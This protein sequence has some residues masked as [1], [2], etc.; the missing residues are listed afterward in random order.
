MDVCGFTACAVLLPILTSQASVSSKK[1]SESLGIASI[2]EEMSAYLS[3]TNALSHS[4]VHSNCL[5]FAVSA[6]NGAAISANVGTNC[7]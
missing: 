6:C 2:G 3:H 5:F 7:R 1:G 4:V